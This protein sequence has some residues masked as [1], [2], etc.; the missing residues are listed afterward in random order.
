[1]TVSKFE[2]C[3]CCEM[4]IIVLVRDKGSKLQCHVCNRQPKKT[5]LRADLKLRWRSS[6]VVTPQVWI[7]LTLGKLEA[8]TVEPLFHGI[9]VHFSFL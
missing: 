7:L 4:V 2:E 8:S 6:R 9:H 3:L 5:K 1:M